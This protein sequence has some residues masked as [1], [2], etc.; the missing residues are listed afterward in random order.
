MKRAMGV[1][2]VGGLVG[3]GVILAGR[4]RRKHGAAYNMDFG[5]P[6]PFL[7]KNTD[8]RYIVEQMHPFSRFEGELFDAIV[9]HMEVLCEALSKAQEKTSDFTSQPKVALHS[10]MILDRILPQFE[11]AVKEQ[12]RGH[13]QLMVSWKDRFSALKDAISD[14]CYNTQNAVHQHML[15]VS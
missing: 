4:W 3:G 14:T 12:G 7:D 11:G 5:I 10:E 15:Y 13:P 8:I 2:A 6:T 1:L 9:T